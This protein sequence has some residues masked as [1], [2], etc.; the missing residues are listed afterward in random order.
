M[1]KTVKSLGL[2]LLTIILVTACN[3]AAQ[4]ENQAQPYQYDQT[5]PFYEG[6]DPYYEGDNR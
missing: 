2:I 4:P 3:P 1:N 6:A 5:D